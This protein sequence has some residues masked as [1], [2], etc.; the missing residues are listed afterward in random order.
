MK[1]L[2]P[3]FLLLLAALFLPSC[4][5][6]YPEGPKIS[7]RD[8]NVRITGEWKAISLIINGQD[9]LYIIDSLNVDRYRF[10]FY[11]RKTE[12]HDKYDLGKYVAVDK[13]GNEIHPDTAFNM[14]SFSDNLSEL[15]IHSTGLYPN[16]PK[17]LAFFPG[18]WN[19]CHL[20]SEKWKIIKLKYKEMKLQSLEYD[21][22]IEMEKVKEL[23]NL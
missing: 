9:K 4:K 6:T 14:C 3:V 2:Y 7:F 22:V 16:N 17:P 20:T 12:S 5:K 11:K 8:V 13:Q 23:I 21:I 10:L 18:Y 19:Y 15:I 1:K